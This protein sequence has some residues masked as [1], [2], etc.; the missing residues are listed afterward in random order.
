M[1]IKGPVV[2]GMTV[3]LPDEIVEPKSRHTTLCPGHDLRKASSHGVTTVVLGK[4]SIKGLL[5]RYTKFTMT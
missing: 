1:T 3:K 4:T 2:L 5:G